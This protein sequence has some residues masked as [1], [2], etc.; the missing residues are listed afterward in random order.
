MANIRAIKTYIDA[1]LSGAPILVKLDALSRYAYA[2]FYP[3]IS[4][5]SGG[6]LDVY[7]TA[8]AGYADTTLSGI[9]VA[10]QIISDG[11]AYYLPA[12][13]TITTE[14]LTYAGEVPVVSVQSGVYLSGTPRIGEVTINGSSWYAK[15]YPVMV[16]AGIFELTK[17]TPTYDSD[18]ISVISDPTYGTFP[19]ITRNGELEASVYSPS[20]F[21][22]TGAVAT[23]EATYDHTQIANGQTAYGWGD[24]AE[25][26]Y[27][28]SDHTHTGV[29]A[30]ASHSH[31]YASSSHTHSEQQFD[32]Y[33]PV[34]ASSHIANGFYCRP[35][36]IASADGDYLSCI[37][38]QGS[39]F[40][41]SYTG[42]SFLG[43]SIPN[44]SVG[45]GTP[46]YKQAVTIDTQTG[47]TGNWG[48]VDY[49]N[50]Y[51]GGNVSAASFTDR[52]PMYN[53]DALEAIKR[54]KGEK[55]NRGLIDHS[56]LPAFAR[57]RVKGTRKSEEYDGRDIGAMVS[58]LTV[59]MQ[60]LLERVEELEAKWN[61]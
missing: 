21:E 12:F 27:A 61:S 47:G 18:F 2:K 59:G 42:G 55:G 57:V 22:L 7:T 41:G 23:H 52:T 31:A 3:T 60:Q 40:F 17:N 13:E 38:I 39:A 10:A 25:A 45:S 14:T 53:D 9:R 34:T 30:A 19:T 37:K 58:V 16:T 51:F 36:L 50:A 46:K 56:T 54:I 24:H 6:S 15:M 28:E 35:L 11:R 4:A 5:A 44:L 33:A 49:N 29:Y 48:I 43:L 26:G 8:L 20:S 32:L 1:T